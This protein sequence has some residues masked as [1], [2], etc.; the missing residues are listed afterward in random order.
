MVKVNKDSGLIT[1]NNK[2]FYTPA[3]TSSMSYLERAYFIA[4]NLARVY[5]N[6]KIKI[7]IVSLLED[8]LWLNDKAIMELTD[9]DD[10]YSL[11]YN[12]NA[13]NAAK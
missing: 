11:I 9:N 4:G 3:A 7:L 6:K 13:A 2:I 10:A 8:T 12:L 1:A 5:H